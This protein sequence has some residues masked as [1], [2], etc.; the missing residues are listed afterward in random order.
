MIQRRE[1]SPGPHGPGSGASCAENIFCTARF[2]RV[3]RRSLR[4]PACAAQDFHL[5]VESQRSPSPPCNASEG[6][7]FRSR[8]S[9]RATRVGN[10]ANTNVKHSENAV[11]GYNMLLYTW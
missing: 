9:L 11:L 1:E 2:A 8:I 10:R 7:S 4:S 6:V 3:P 5:S